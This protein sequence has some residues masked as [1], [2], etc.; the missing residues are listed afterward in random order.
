MSQ[1]V[2]LV[3]LAAVPASV[4]VAP[5]NEEPLCSDLKVLVTYLITLIVQMCESCTGG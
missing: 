2:M 1:T 5:R 3:S 4:G